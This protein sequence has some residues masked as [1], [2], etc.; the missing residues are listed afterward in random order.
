MSRRSR[1][2]GRHLPRSKRKKMRGFSP[3]AQQ[4]IASQRHEPEPRVE[5]VAPPVK[6]P[7]PR[8]TAPLIQTPYVSAEL[9]MIGILS[10]IIVAILIALAFILP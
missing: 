6:A 1:R 7:T 10:G 5:A 2:H 9:K 4:P 8:P 3:P